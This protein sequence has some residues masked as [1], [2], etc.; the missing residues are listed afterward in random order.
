MLIYSEIA[1]YVCL[2]VLSIL[3]PEHVIVLSYW[4]IVYKL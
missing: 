3:Q 1:L 4:V 2:F